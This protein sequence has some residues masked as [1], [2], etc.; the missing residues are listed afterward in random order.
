LAI[1]GQ[2]SR[3]LLLAVFTLCSIRLPYVQAGTHARLA[4]TEKSLFKQSRALE[5]SQYLL[6]ILLGHNTSKRDIAIRLQAQCSNAS[7]TKPLEAESGT[8]SRDVLNYWKMKAG[9][10]S[11]ARTIQL[12]NSDVHESSKTDPHKKRNEKTKELAASMFCLRW[13][14]EHS[15]L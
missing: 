14:L 12:Q 7:A 3:D 1:P 2:T 10:W 8:S 11:S 9:E 15:L 4:L 13:R 5:L 6:G